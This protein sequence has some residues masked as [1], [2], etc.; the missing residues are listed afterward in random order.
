MATRI[1]NGAMDD[2]SG[3]ATVLDIAHR[4]KNGPSPRRS[5]LFAIFT[6]E[7]KGLLGSQLFRRQS[8]GAEKRH[9]RRPEFRH[10]AAAWPLKMVY[11]PGETEST[12]GRGCPRGGGCNKASTVVPDPLPDRNVFI[13]TDQY[14][15]VREGVPALFMKFGFAKDTPEFQIE[16]DWR[17]NRYH[18]P[19]DDLDQPGVFKEEAVK[20]DAYT[21]ALALRVA[22]ADTRPQ[23]LPDSI[24]GH[25]SH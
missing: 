11:L 14:S 10:A 8:H 17:A 4:L 16:H 3:V 15:F 2:A 6:A 18:S 20:L 19:S 5:I 24:F 9:C 7:E 22:N 21:A 23:W 25:G 1:Y 12:L 13:R